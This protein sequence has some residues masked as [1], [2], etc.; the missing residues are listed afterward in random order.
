MKLSTVFNA[1]LTVVIA[2]MLIW[3]ALFVNRWA[4]ESRIL[5]RMVDRLSAESRVAEVLVTKSEFNEA[6]RKIDTTIKFLEYDASGEALQPKYFTFQGNIIQFQALVIRF[7]DRMV[8]A[9]DKLRGKS[10]FVFLKA[11]ILDG[12]G[13]Q[14][15]DI[16]VVGEV[17]RGYRVSEEP[18]DFEKELWS[19]FWS[20]ALDPETR[21]RKG[22]KNAQI[23]APGSM[24]VPGTIYTLRIEHDGGLRI[25]AQPLPRILKG[26]TL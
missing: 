25:D 2:G 23:E 16:T 7:E 15:F 17:P 24:F 22:I 3:A 5:R 11:F 14:S 26:E 19:E 10:A 20:Y 8:L 6:T 4:E 12:P 9:G 13:T 1:V 18:N 21:E